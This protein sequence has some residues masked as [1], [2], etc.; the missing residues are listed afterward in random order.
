MKP[1]RLTVN[2]RQVVETVE[3]RMH[4]A[5]F[6]REKMNLTGTHLRCEQGVCG[7]CTLLIDGQPARSC[8]TYAMMCDG[9]VIT[10]I[11]GLDDDPVMTALRR[12]FSEEHGLQCGFCTPAMLVTARDIIAR[13]PEAD[14]AR[15]RLELSGNLC[16]C[17]GYVGI[18]RAIRRVLKECR[19][20]AFVAP[21]LPSAPLGP[22]GARVAHSAALERSPI[23]T[24]ASISG[25][26]D[27]GPAQDALGLGGRRPNI[28]LLQSFEVSC[29]PKDVW[30][31]FGDIERVVRCLPGASLTRPPDGDRVDGKFSARLGPITATFTGAARIVRDDEKL[32]GVVLGAGNDRLSGSRAAGEIEYVLLPA[33]RGTRV[34]LVIRALLAGPLAQFG[35]SGIV[36][37]LV[38]RVAQAFARNLEARLMGSGSDIETS[39]SVPLAAGLLLRQVLATRL[40]AALAR[41]FQ[42]GGSSPS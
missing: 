33:G 32:R 30:E 31:F 21:L 29:S 15:I 3:A 14:E 4:L 7:A 9:A 27:S 24:A 36:E 5:D 25:R 8:I 19:E 26:S 38:S 39:T 41:L 28:E 20:G 37:D 40:K 13:V 18:V 35:R 34:E 11:E 23:T 42:L 6:L 12:A 22:V 16:R 2:G 10:T 1:I 17:T